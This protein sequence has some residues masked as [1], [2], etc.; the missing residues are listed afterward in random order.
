MPRYVYERLSPAQLSAGLNEADVT[1]HQFCRLT[2]ADPRRVERWLSGEQA[3]PPLWVGM[4]LTAL[5]CP[6]ARRKMLAYA[7][8]VVR[9]SRREE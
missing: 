3:D 6:E 1:L 4:I 8:I 5:T 9:D 2:G 7:D